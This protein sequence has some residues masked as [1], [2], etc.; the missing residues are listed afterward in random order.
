MCAFALRDAAD[1]AA[2][3]SPADWLARAMRFEQDGEFF[4][5]YDV[6]MQALAA[7]DT[8]GGIRLAK[9]LT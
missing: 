2:G 6:A 1:V 7:P 9:D 5:A 8:V 3:A 4:K